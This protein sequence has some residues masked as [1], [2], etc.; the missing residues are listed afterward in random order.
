MLK[1]NFICL[2]IFLFF[3]VVDTKAQPAA[4]IKVINPVAFKY[5][6]T[7]Y[8]LKGKVK[9]LSEYDA[10]G[11]VSEE[12]EFDTAGLL[13]KITNYSPAGTTV[14][15]YNF[16]KREITVIQNNASFKGTYSYALNEAGFITSR[17]G[18]LGGNET[19]TYD[20]KMLLTSSKNSMYGTSR[21]EY[22]AEGQLIKQ[23]YYSGNGDLAGM[24]TY[25]Y[26]QDDKKNQIVLFQSDEDG[27]I[28]NK[29]IYYSEK[30]V[31]I[32]ETSVSADKTYTDRTL[33]TNDAT[34]NWITKN[35]SSESKQPNGEMKKGTNWVIKR[36]I[37]YY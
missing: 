4:P 22:N 35:S 23:Y 1:L 37:E 17:T 29:L 10:S 21:Y 8:N 5:K 12:Y 13:K 32:R 7:D 30:H 9:K 14:L 16:K 15:V 18:G 27:E 19:Y 6:L 2:S 34:G 11:S 28:T 3:I 24:Y 31:L 33:Y 25:S 20:S 26:R 36:T